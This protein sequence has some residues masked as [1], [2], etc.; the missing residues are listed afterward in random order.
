MSPWQLTILSTSTASSTRRNYAIHKSCANCAAGC[1]TSHWMW[2]IFPQLAGLGYSETSKFYAL[3]SLAE[4]EAY[5]SH[6]F[7]GARLI[8][9]LEALQSLPTN[10]P[11]AV[12]GSIDAAKLRSCL[13]LFL[14]V[15]PANQGR[16]PEMVRGQS[17]SCHAQTARESVGRCLGRPPRIPAEVCNHA[18][19]ERRKRQAER[20]AAQMVYKRAGQ[21]RNYGT[22]KDGDV[23]DA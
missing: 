3:R 17:R 1:K 23:H 16:P 13:T 19:A 2:F 15:A 7:L 11:D 4:A 14:D 12:L 21:H 18:V 8:E 9:C 6:E 22:P 5:L 10:D 20:N